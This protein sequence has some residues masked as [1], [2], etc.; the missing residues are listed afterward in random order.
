MQATRLIVQIIGFTQIARL[1]PKSSF[2][3]AEMV[4]IVY[5][6]YLQTPSPGKVPQMH[7]ESWT[8]KLNLLYMCLGF[9]N[10]KTKILDAIVLPKMIFQ[11]TI[12]HKNLVRSNIHLHLSVY[13]VLILIFWHMAVIK[14]YLSDRFY[15][16][17]FIL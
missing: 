15:A 7:C 3:W 2:I 8:F 12:I 13:K 11:L 5:F 1:N 9:R 10:D 17:P 16:F 14:K 6:P 4:L